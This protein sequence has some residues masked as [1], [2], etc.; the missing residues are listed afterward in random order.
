MKFWTF[1]PLASISSFILADDENA[2]TRKSKT[3]SKRNG[4]NESLI[5]FH[6]VE[7]KKTFIIG[8]VRLDDLM[9]LVWRELIA[10]I[11]S[12]ANLKDDKL[13]E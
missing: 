13:I 2:M 9:L 7:R 6:A 10:E 12:S 1:F 8:R 4:I 5:R 3:I 11:I